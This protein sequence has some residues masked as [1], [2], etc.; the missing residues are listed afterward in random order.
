MKSYGSIKRGTST[1]SERTNSKNGSKTRHKL[2]KQKIWVTSRVVKSPL[3]LS[4]KSVK[5]A[6]GKKLKKGNQTQRS[7]TT[8][9]SQL[10]QQLASKSSKM[11]S[12][13]KEKALKTSRSRNHAKIGESRDN[14][15]GFQTH[16]VQ[17]NNL[18]ES[19]LLGMFTSFLTSDK[20]TL[21]ERKNS[22]K[23]QYNDLIVTQKNLLS[24]L[25]KQKSP[26]VI[27]KSQDVPMN[28]FNIFKGSWLEKVVEEPV[29]KD[30]PFNLL[31]LNY[32]ILSFD[33]KKIKNPK[34][35]FKYAEDTTGEDVRNTATDCH[36]P[37]YY[38]RNKHRLSCETG[39]ERTT[40][41]PIGSTPQYNNYL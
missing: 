27:D 41:L 25:N 21:K 13:A 5:V 6:K 30:D 12:V 38:Q 1:E 39:G 4:K 18:S 17:N 29:Q 26:K 37:G 23:N 15:K 8:L 33:G 34:A 22:H 9:S 32:E 40:Q 19:G 16:R 20:K 28:G 3:K 11:N 31:D 24:T 14:Q 7:T 36:S 35:S 2:S 10:M